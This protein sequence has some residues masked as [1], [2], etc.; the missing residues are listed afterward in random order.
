MPNDFDSQRVG[1]GDQVLQGSTWRKQAYPQLFGA[2]VSQHGGHA[3]NVIG[4]AMGNRNGIEARD[5]ARP[6]VGCD[7]IFTEVELRASAP[8]GPAGVDEQGAALRH[9]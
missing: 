9:D 6:Q 7:Y 3:T 1:F 2:E 8:D 4:M 5:A